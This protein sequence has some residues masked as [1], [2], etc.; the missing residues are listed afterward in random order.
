MK[1]HITSPKM[2]SLQDWTDQVSFD[3]DI[4]VPV[5]RM[6]DDDWQTWGAQ[7][8]TILNQ[9]PN[10]YYF[11]DWREWGDRFYEVLQ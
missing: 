9:I 2:L 8:I 11:N 4:V 6:V 7:F 10:P 3:L 1:A 5:C